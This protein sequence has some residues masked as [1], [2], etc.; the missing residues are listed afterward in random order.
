MIGAYEMK[1]KQA[2]MKPTNYWELAIYCNDFIYR[3]K[4]YHTFIHC[5]EEEQDI[6]LANQ[7]YTELKSIDNG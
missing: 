1:R 7:L 4:M 6:Q 3:G 5:Y 2:F